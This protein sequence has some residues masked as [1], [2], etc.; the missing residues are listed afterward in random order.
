MAYYRRQYDEPEEYYAYHDID[1][2]KSQI[3]RD[4]QRDNLESYRF[5][6][7]SPLI[8]K[9]SECVIPGY[10]NGVKIRLSRVK[11]D[12]LV[13]SPV[14]TVR[15]RESVVNEFGLAISPKL[16]EFVGDIMH[17]EEV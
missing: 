17:I 10:Q 16:S 15:N 4:I 14:L 8:S 3:R 11:G 12:G 7:S 2:H 1:M 13:Y 6:I 5:V 9:E